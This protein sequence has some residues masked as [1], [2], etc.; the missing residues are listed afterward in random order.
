MIQTFVD[1]EHG[2]LVWRNR[3][4]QD[5]IVNC[6]R[7]P[8]SAY[9]VLHRA[10]CGSLV[11]HENYTTRDYIKVCG[12]TRS[13]LDRWAREEIGGELTRCQECSP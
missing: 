7:K 2:F 8:S 9:L 11:R 12:E 4:W 5:F 6:Y 13:E 10:D 3:H 1:D